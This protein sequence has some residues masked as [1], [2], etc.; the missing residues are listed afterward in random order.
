[1][2][3]DI[4]AGNQIAEALDVPLAA[5][6]DVTATNPPDLPGE[7]DPSRAELAVILGAEY[8]PCQR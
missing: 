4:A 6:Q 8:D 1:L 7:T 3:G 5:V 2:Q